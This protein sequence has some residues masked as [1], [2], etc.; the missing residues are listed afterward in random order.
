MSSCGATPF[1]HGQYRGQTETRQGQ[2]ET[3]KSDAFM[4]IRRVALAVDHLDYLLIT[5]GGCSVREGTQRAS[6]V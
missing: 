5:S 4:S 6:N 2:R 3:R 1:G